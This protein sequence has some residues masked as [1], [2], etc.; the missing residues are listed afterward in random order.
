M[1]ISDRKY[2]NR[3]IAIALNSVIEQQR[4]EAAKKHFPEKRIEW[5]RAISVK[6]VELV[7]KEMERYNYNNP[8]EPVKANDAVST[9]TTALDWI[10]K[11]AAIKIIKQ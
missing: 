2:G 4:L 7:D 10:L 11:D 5:I 1:G 9:V 6:I 8:Y 3:Q